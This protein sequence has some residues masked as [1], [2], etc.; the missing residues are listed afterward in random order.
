MAVSCC[1]CGRAIPRERSE[2]LFCSEGCKAEYAKDP[3]QSISCGHCSAQAD[4]ILEAEA[5]GWKEIEMHVEGYSWN[6]LG[7]CPDCVR[8]GFV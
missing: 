6:F 1:R 4:G 8:E 2:S 5:A 7:T 3:P